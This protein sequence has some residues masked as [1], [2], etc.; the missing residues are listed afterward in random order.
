[1][2]P[3]AF[4]LAIAL[5]LPTFVLAAPPISEQQ[6]V[7][8]A[9]E[10][11]GRI[12]DYTS[13]HPHEP[14]VCPAWADVGAGAAEVEHREVVLIHSYPDLEPSYYYVALRTNDTGEGTFVT[15]DAVTGEWQAFGSTHSRASFPA[16]SRPEAAE[17]ASRQ[18][19]THIVASSLRAVS[20]PNKHIYW[21]WADGAPA[22]QSARQLFINLND[23]S[24]VHTTPDDEIAPRPAQQPP[25]PE[26]QTDRSVHGTEPE[27]SGRYPTS[28][29]ISDV[30]HH[31]Q[32]TSYDCGPASSEMV[33]DYYG[34]DIVQGDIADVA[35][36][37]SSVGCYTDDL[38]RTGHFSGISTAAQ[39]PSLYGY[40][41]RKLG[42]GS[43]ENRWSYPNTSDPDYADRYNDLREIISQDFPLIPL[44][45]YDSSH[46]G[47]HY[48]VIKGYN[49]STNVF[50]VH[51][52]WYTG[53]Y[54]GPDVNFNQNFFVDNLW[55]NWYRWALFMC[56]WEVQIDCPTDVYQGDT[57]TVNAIIYYQGPH[58]YEGQDSASSRSVTISMSQIFSLAS[59]ETATVSLPGS[60]PSGVG[61]FVSWQVV[62]DTVE[63]GGIISVRA[64][65]YITD[66][67]SSYSS[68]AD[69]IGGWASQ[70]VTIWPATGVDDAMANTLALHPAR[71]S[72][73][74]GETALELEL[75]PEAGE[76]R[77][78]IYDA[79]GRRVKTLVEGPV[80]PGRRELVWNGTDDEGRRVA[81]G[82]YFALLDCDAGS[83]SQKIVLM[84]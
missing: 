72:P 7:S 62:A 43:M 46:G 15:L 1:M 14:G 42:Y 57:F 9:C 17:L 12:G 5:V 56:P 37:N 74:T 54:Q 3:S 8:A 20:M 39:N 67:S 21:Y 49:D 58:P 2:R 68:Y 28:Y 32:L 60:A 38:R 48:R 47:G 23:P 22:E 61:N 16:V 29:D 6:A 83:R 79:A 53:T 33:M 27:G 11:A 84:R 24:D 77:L 10:L 4:A 81:A 40:D 35:N 41:E 65:G 50:I 75:P 55:T 26:S 19:G 64:E 73:F 13:R 59:G 34:A 52:P 66:S 69:S 30:P 45:W 80:E 71:P 25:P 31:Y 44:T 82:V 76:V 36:S 78:S 51:D 63:L 18:T 70:G